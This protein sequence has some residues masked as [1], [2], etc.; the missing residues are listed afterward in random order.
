MARLRVCYVA[1]LARWHVVGSYARAGGSPEVF[2][3]GAQDGAVEGEGRPVAFALE[4]GQSRFGPSEVGDGV[5][6]SGARLGGSSQRPQHLRTGEPDLLGILYLGHTL[7]IG[8]RLRAVGIGCRQV[9]QAQAGDGEE[10]AVNAGVEVT[11]SGA[12]G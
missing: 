12:Q 4:V 2:V 6:Q 7:Q 8:K 3:G 5:F 11:L 9:A 10:G 1:K